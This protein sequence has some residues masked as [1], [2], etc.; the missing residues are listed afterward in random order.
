M[1]CLYVDSRSLSS[2]NYK[3]TS[4]YMEHFYEVA[5]TDWGERLLFFK[6]N[7]LIW[8]KSG[9]VEIAFII[10]KS[11]QKSDFYQYFTCL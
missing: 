6:G 7:G 3:H 9:Y 8:L 4:V 5:P 1:D 11:P 2:K 10:T